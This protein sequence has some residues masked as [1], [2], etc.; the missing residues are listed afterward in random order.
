MN[1][2]HLAHPDQP[3]YGACGAQF[4][5]PWCTNT[6]TDFAGVTCPS[7]LDITRDPALIGAVV[8][9]D[10]VQGWFV[11]ALQHGL[12]RPGTNLVTHQGT[13]ERGLLIEVHRDDEHRT[14]MGRFWVRVTVQ[15]P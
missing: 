3:G 4:G 5:T 14:P 13:D 8:G 9:V 12:P 7:C 6:T 1:P 15:R 10:Q 11:E 2:T